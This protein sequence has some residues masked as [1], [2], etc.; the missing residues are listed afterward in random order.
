MSKLEIQKI[1][2]T[3]DRKLP[4][5]EEFDEIADRIRV[6][7]YNLFKNR[8]FGLGQDL[9]DWLMAEREIC[10]PAAE[11]IE[12]DDEFEIKVALAGFE[13]KD[14]TVTATPR[15][16]IIKASHKDERK[17]SE[18]E[19]GSRVRWSEFRSSDVYRRIELPA[20]VNVDKI[21]AELERGMLEIEAPK[22]TRPKVKKKK[23][24]RRKVKVSTSK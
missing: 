17:K 10:W 8:G 6:R 5:F 21:S 12:E 22:A 2:T 14:I 9:D 24:T 20:D 1:P 7:A 13:P 11:L 3:E 16:L 4:I 19:E 18:E 23:A 15:E